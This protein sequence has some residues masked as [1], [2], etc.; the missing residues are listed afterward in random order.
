M[1]AMQSN[2]AVPCWIMSHHRIAE[3]LPAELGCFDLVIIDEASQSDLTALPALLRAR[4]ILVVGDD[5]QVSPEGVGLEEEK[6][7]SLMNRFLTGQVATY[8]P[9]MSPERSMYDLFK[10]VFA[11]SNVML[12]EHFRCVAPIIEYSKREFYNHE[13][14][15][16]RVPQASQRLDPP[17]IDVLV[18]DG[19]RK[20]DLNLAEVRFIVDEIKRIITDQAMAHRTIGVVSLLGDK[21]A[22]AVWE[23]LIEEV[24][25]EELRRHRIECGDARAFQGKER[26]IMFLTM[27]AAPNEVGAPL[28]RDTFA[29]RFNVA[30]SRAQD[31]MYLVRSVEFDHLSSADRLRRSL[32][33]H[34]STPFAQDETRVENLR[35]LCESPFER[36]LYD[37]LT[38]RGYW[39]TPQVKVGQYRIDLVVE[40][41]NDMRLAVECDGDRY[42]G[43][44][45][46]IEDMDR[47]RVLERAGWTFWRSFASA[48][49]RR[50]DSVMNELLN[51]LTE[52]GVEAIGGDR[53]PRSLHSEFRR[54][55]VAV[56]VPVG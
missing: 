47:Q 9:Q 21:Q 43:S 53:A 54:I 22:Y 19:Y 41:N 29:Q 38:Q 52:N 6:V 14:R 36:E 23:R 39:V 46:W 12:R 28:S 56:D 13:L 55:P 27:V 24:G 26:H 42:H 51:A 11:R 37:E 8:R 4:K 44:D 40:G 15:P 1:A 17:L 5:K 7:R 49:V 3:T 50:R 45:K 34:F 33:T 10:V 35:T 2:P 18:E 31:R 32:I 16:L 25:P 30:A 20:G 48:F